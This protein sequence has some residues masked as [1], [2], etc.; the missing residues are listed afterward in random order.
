MAGIANGA[1]LS[2]LHMSVRYSK[3]HLDQGREDEAQPSPSPLVF[4][5]SHRVQPHFFQNISILV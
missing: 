3:P 2:G 5:T 4:S 1:G